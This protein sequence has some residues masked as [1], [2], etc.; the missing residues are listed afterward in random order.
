MSYS[1]IQINYYAINGEM[2]EL[3][4]QSVEDYLNALACSYI[5]CCCRWAGR[6]MTNIDE[7]L[8]I[9]FPLATLFQDVLP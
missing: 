9:W 4:S 5:Y 1:I 6:V 2:K 3:A 7:T 8:K